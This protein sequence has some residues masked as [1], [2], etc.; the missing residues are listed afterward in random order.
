M[1]VPVRTLFKH[2]A[3]Y[4]KAIGKL[5]GVI[6]IL[7]SLETILSSLM[8]LQYLIAH[9]L[10]IVFSLE[11]NCFTILWFLSY[12]NM[13]QPQ[14]YICP[15]PPEPLFHLPPH[16]TP[17]DCHRAR[18]KVPVSQSKLPLAI[19]LTYGNVCLHAILSFHPPSFPHCVCSLCLCLHSCPAN[20][21]ISTI[22]LDSIHMH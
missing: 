5:E 4:K 18:F 1:I 3:H 8:S 2:Y 16:P 21:F 11:D 7:Q 20:G 13:N 10:K 12:T 9:F 19:Y 17:L 15:L 14:V 6:V 22:F